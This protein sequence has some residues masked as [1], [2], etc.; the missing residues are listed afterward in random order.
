VECQWSHLLSVKSNTNGYFYFSATI[1]VLIATNLFKR[2]QKTKFYLLTL[3]LLNG[4]VEYV[5]LMMIRNG[6]HLTHI[7]EHQLTQLRFIVASFCVATFFLA[8]LF[9]GKSSSTGKIAGSRAAASVKSNN[10]SNEHSYKI[11]VYRGSGGES[12]DAYLANQ[13]KKNTFKDRL[14]QLAQT[15]NTRLISSQFASYMDSIDDLKQYRN[16]F[17]YPLNEKTGKPL[18]YLCGNSL[19]LQPKRVTQYVNEELKKWA[20]VGVEGHFTGTRPWFNIED[21][22]VELMA[23]VVGAKPIEVAVC[24]TLTVNEHLLL[25]S[26]YQPTAKRHKIL[27]EENPFP[28]DMHAIISHIKSVRNGTD[29]RFD[30]EESL[31]QI[32]PRKGEDF[33][34]TEDILDLLEKQG[35]EI[36]LILLGGVHFMSGQAFDYETITK[37]GHEKG[38]IVGFDFA[39]GAGNI[40]LKLHDWD[41]DFACW[42]TYK[43]L[44]SGPGNLGGMFVH[45]RHAYKNLDEL[46]RYAGWW[47]HKRD[48]RFRLT[49]KFDPQPGAAS[50][51]LSNPIVLGM[52]AVQASLELFDKA[53]IAQLR[54]KSYLLTSYLE[55]LIDSELPKDVTILT[56]RDPKLRGCQLSLRFNTKPLDEVMD[57]LKESGVICDE[58]E[59]DIIRIAPAPLYNTFEEVYNCVMILKAI[60][61]N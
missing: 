49:N 42:C 14:V 1:L 40:D 17:F 37:K 2:T 26:F 53:T 4:A 55:M 15:Q 31:I 52:V 29:E 61:R 11:Q 30:P 33:V 21:Y 45:E 54:Q 60:H 35:D 3:L 25:V 19:G 46:P 56:P 10:K 7:N 39:H 32:G 22:V 5:A 58:R 13:A 41:V 8:L 12:K 16:E 38:C 27:I 24:H 57:K 50:W 6:S 44:N 23:R 47:G 9:G 28:S 59:P 48:T 20:E 34:R 51:Q 18:T 43:Y 36:A